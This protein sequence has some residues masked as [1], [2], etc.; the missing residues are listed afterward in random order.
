MEAMISIFGR[1]GGDTG[2]WLGQWLG[3]GISY[4]FVFVVIGVAQVLLKRGVLGAGSTRKVVHIGVAHWWLL[5]MLFIDNLAV[6]LV[7]PVS[8][9]VI[10][11][12]SWRRHI[13]AAMEHEEPRKNLGTIYFPVALTVLVLLTWSGLFPRW[14]GLLAILVL[15][16]GDGSASLLG[17]RFGGRRGGAGGDMDGG[18]PGHESGGAASGRRGQGWVFRQFAVPGGRKSVIGTVAMFLASGMV[19]FVVL[20]VVVGLP[21]VSPGLE[22]AG[23]GAVATW[24][25]R[26]APGVTTGSWVARETDS[27]VLVALSRL[28]ALV[29]VGVDRAAEGV[30]GTPVTWELAPTTIVSM[31]LIIAAVATAVELVTPWGL[32]NITIPLTVFVVLTGLLVLPEGWVVRLAWALGLNVFLAAGAYLKRSIT[33]GGAVA[34]ATVGLVIFLSGGGFFWSVLIAFFVSSSLL[35]R[36]KFAGPGSEAR[37]R[38]E[39]RR[40][41]ESINAK[42]SRRDAVQVLANGGLAALMAAGHA[43]T[44]SPFFMLGFAIVLAAANADTWASEIGVLS[45][46]EPI[47]IITWKPILRGSSGGISS[48]GLIAGTLG[49]LFIGMWFA[50]GYVVT[51]GWNPL[52]VLPLVAAIT[53]GGF[54]GSLIDS[55]LGGSVQAQYWDHLRETYTERRHNAAGVANRLVRGFHGITNDAVNA[56]SGLASMAVLLSIVA[57]G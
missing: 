28:D 35:S 45:R 19:A 48:L 43:V 32:D 14:Y 22:G 29:R 30:T 37:R 34:G 26:F 38:R 41:A 12:V 44:A 3:L 10:N 51:R 31:A 17:E 16:W 39:A 27:T 13:F 8:F 49:A 11:Y 23:P 4:L 56:L 52:E 54:L 7:G 5:A 47:S 55:V 50:L 18:D 57:Q 9:I 1:I 46:R 20:S 42:G 33:A 21:S 24:F 25:D 36:L 2:Q 15:G 6:A 40:Q 53:G